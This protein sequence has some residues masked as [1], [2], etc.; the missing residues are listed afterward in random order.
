[1]AKNKS[2]IKESTQRIRN[3]ADAIDE[4]IDEKGG[5]TYGDPVVSIY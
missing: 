5:K 4:E 1:M 2:N 3:E